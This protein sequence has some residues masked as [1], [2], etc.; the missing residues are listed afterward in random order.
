MYRLLFTTAFRRVPAEAAHQ[1]GFALIRAAA[2]LSWVSWLR[3]PALSPDDP[4]LR[5][6]A[7]GLD[8]PGPLGLAAGFDKDARAPDALG[9][10]GFAFIEIGTV[11]A[12]P[13]S[14]NPRPRLFRL[15][16][17]QALI[18]RMGFNNDGARTVATARVP[19]PGARPSGSTSAR[20]GS[21][22]STMRRRLRRQR[23]PAGRGR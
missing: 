15:P 14:G 18:N 9:A 4:V 21:S 16:Y 17:D 5:I 8:L 3:G 23:Q 20:P 19:G 1:A 13:Q 2:A 6:Q 22:P 7:L 10:L 11:T 12:L